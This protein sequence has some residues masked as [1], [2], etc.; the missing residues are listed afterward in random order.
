MPVGPLMIEHRLIEKMIARM[1]LEARKM[2]GGSKPDLDFVRAAVDF[3]KVYA[4]RLHHGKEEE[5][6][7]R[8][9]EKKPLSADEKRVMDELVQEHVI[10][11][12]KTAM[13]IKLR[14][15]LLDGDESAAAPLAE[16]MLYLAD[17]YPKHIEKEDKH[18]FIPVMRHFS[19]EEQDAMIAEFDEFDRQ[20]V[21]HV[22]SDV[23]KEWKE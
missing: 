10:G 9:L 23:V 3:I 6:L 18:F 12:E 21:H 5:I 17:F 1:K 22:Y 20:F 2:A 11:R 19:R 16:A 15:R 8:D 14:K 4:D 13:L 7:F